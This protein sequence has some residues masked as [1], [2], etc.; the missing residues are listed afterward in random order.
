M[1]FVTNEAMEL[2]KKYD[3]PGNIRELENAIESIVIL[4]KSD[5]ITKKDIPQNILTSIGPLGKDSATMNV[6]N[7][8]K[9]LIVNALKKTGGNKTKAAEMLGISRKTIHR[10]LKEYSIET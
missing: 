3:W 2:L 9:D 1:E 10:K 6:K 4:S 8:E 7:N 5:K